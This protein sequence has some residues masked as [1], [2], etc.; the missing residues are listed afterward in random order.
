M[1]HLHLVIMQRALHLLFARSWL[2]K[3]FGRTVVGSETRDQLSG[4][5]SRGHLL[6][7]SVN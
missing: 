4:E 7:Q 5:S 2:P 6:L 1:V 3:H